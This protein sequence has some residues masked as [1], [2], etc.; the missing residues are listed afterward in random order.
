[1]SSGCEIYSSRSFLSPYVP[2][3]ADIEGFEGFF[4]YKKSL[5]AE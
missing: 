4:I 2:I 1:M 5:F 3:N